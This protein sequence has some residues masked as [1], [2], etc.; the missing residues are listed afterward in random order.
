MPEIAQLLQT[1]N[2]WF[3][4]TTDCLA[5]P[6]SAPTCHAFW[7][8][9]IYGSAGVG[10]ALLLW[11]A[12]KLIDYL[13]QIFAARRA[14]WEHERVADKATMR[15]YVWDDDKYTTDEVTDP[16]LAEKIRKELELRRLHN[17]ESGS[18]SS[19]P[20]TSRRS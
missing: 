19:G 2:R 3:G 18:R 1:I 12:W 15:Q 16:K 20:V 7:E 13:A 8:L 5:S 6:V 14:Q 10:L 4:H 11:A 9:V 17:M